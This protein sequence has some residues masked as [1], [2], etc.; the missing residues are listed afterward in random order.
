MSL[1]RY[2]HRAWCTPA[3]GEKFSAV[4]L[5][6]SL[7]LLLTVLITF[8]VFE[9]GM[10]NK[11]VKIALPKPFSGIGEPIECAMVFKSYMESLHSWAKSNRCDS[12]LTGGGSQ[13]DSAYPMQVSKRAPDYSYL[14]AKRFK[15][16]TPGVAAAAEVVEVQAVAHVP[17]VLE[18]LDED[19][20][21]MVV[22]RFEV[23]A[24]AYVAPRPA[25]TAVEEVVE[26]VF[27]FDEDQRYQGHAKERKEIA[28]YEYELEIART[29]H[30]LLKIQRAE[31]LF[32]CIQSSTSGRAAKVVSSVVEE[33]SLE[34]CSIVVELFQNQFN[35]TSITS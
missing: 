16:T 30:D 20:D 23:R 7:L 33:D 19:G 13:Y 5:L 6:P 34:R 29:A 22:A 17:A 3:S 2:Q 8:V 27:I 15:V 12:F 18:E 9:A 26:E 14:D 10:D 21:V 25:V 31:A 1:L 4:I 24:V 28:D 35:V 11:G 32:A